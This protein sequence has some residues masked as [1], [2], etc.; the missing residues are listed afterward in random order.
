[1]FPDIEKKLQETLDRLAKE[2]V[3]VPVKHPETGETR[4]ITLDRNAFALRCPS[5]LSGRTAE[6]LKTSANR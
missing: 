1:M 5:P 6:W 3:R 4:E 2:P